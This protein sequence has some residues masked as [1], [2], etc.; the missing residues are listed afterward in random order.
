MRTTKPLLLITHPC[1]STIGVEA[2][3]VGW[4]KGTL[5]ETEL[6]VVS[7]DR[8]LLGIERTVPVG[9]GEISASCGRMGNPPRPVTMNLLSP[10]LLADPQP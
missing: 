6:R 2:G 8:S 9:Y 3:L 4:V 1:A 10:C 5:P 7:L